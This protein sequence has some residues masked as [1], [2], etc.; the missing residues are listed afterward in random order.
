MI[1]ER[2]PEDAA[3]EIS[4]KNKVAAHT[5]RVEVDVLGSYFDWSGLV[6]STL[7]NSVSAGLA[8]AVVAFF[9]WRALAWTFGMLCF[10]DTIRFARCSWLSVTDCEEAFL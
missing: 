4:S 5:G 10:V 7:A 3:F 2:D 9:D 8:V 1:A 6:R